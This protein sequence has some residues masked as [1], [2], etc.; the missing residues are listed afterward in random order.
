[1][2]VGHARTGTSDWAGL[3]AQISAYLEPLVHDPDDLDDVA[4]LC[5]VKVW[6]KGHTFRGRSKLSTWVY[7]LVRNE[8][9][10]WTRRRASRLRAD[11]V[12]ADIAIRDGAARFETAVLNKVVVDRALGDLPAADRLLLE[13]QF[14]ND[15]TSAQVGEELGLAPSSVRCRLRRIKLARR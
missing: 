1:M 4:Q 3:A 8:F 14:R 10:S 2:S 11:R 7:R 13:L 5:L 15:W 12:W 6:Q 9:V